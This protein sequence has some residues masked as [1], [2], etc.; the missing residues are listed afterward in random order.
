MQPAQLRENGFDPVFGSQAVFRRLLE[1]AARPGAV[2]ALSELTPQIP[3]KHLR[4]ACA[5][6]LSLLDLEVGL[7]VLGP[8]AEEIAEYLH[9]NTDARHVPLE[10]ADFIL[11]IGPDSGGRISRVKR[12]SLLSPHEGSTIV[13]APEALGAPPGPRTVTL[14]VSGPGVQGEARLGIT[15]ICREEW[16]RLRGLMDFPLGVDIWLAAADGHLAVLP[17]SAHWAEEA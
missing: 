12:G 10:D 1:A 15:G 13:Y 9:F 6:L 7:H 5:L 8:E 2:M 11:V 4:P 3:P 17:R 16:H 14:S